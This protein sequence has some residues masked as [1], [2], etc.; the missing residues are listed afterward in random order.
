M[1]RSLKSP[2][3]PATPHDMFLTSADQEFVSSPD[4][5]HSG[6]RYWRSVDLPP[7]LGWFIAALVTRDRRLVRHRTLLI[8]YEPDLVALLGEDSSQILVALQYMSPPRKAENGGWRGHRIRRI[9]E[10]SG[11]RRTVPVLYFDTTEGIEIPGWFHGVDPEPIVRRELLM[12]F[13]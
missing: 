12:E 7:R 11:E 13:E 9:W 2:S 4:M 5:A 6:A 3:L 10:A 8:A 1:T